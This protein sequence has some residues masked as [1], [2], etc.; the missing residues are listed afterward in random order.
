MINQ[1]EHDHIV[2]GTPEEIH[3]YSTSKSLKGEKV[4]VAIVKQFPLILSFALTCHK[5]QGITVK[6]PRKV[7]VDS[8]TVWGASQA[9]VMLRRVE[10]LCQLFI[11]ETLPRSKIYCDNYIEFQPGTSR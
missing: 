5:I 4:N 9:Y 1:K 8:R 10:R 11:I 6:Y 2:W 7:A 3:K